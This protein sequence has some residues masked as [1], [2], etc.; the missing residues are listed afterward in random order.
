MLHAHGRQTQ[1]EAAESLSVVLRQEW[2]LRDDVSKG[3]KGKWLGVLEDWWPMTERHKKGG[4]FHQE[5]RE[6]QEGPCSP[7]T[8][9]GK[10]QIKRESSNT[11]PGKLST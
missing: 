10:R 11:V 9:L 6:T 1:L 5:A 7:A 4:L 2:L 3:V 8:L